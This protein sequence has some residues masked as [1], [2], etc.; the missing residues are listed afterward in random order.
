MLT[1]GKFAGHLFL[2][3]AVLLVARCAWAQ[4][5]ATRLLEIFPAGGNPGQSFEVTIH[6]S[7]LDDA[8]TLH[9]SHAGITA[10][11]K[12]A[13]PG[14]FDDG[15]K[16]VK[17]QFVVTVAGNVPLGVYEARAV[18]KYGMS[19]PRAFRI[20]DVPAALEEEPN[21][22]RDHATGLQLPVS[23]SGR[24]EQQADVDYFKFEATAAGRLVVDCFCRRIDSQTDAVVAVYDA[25]GRILASSRDAQQRDPLVDVQVAAGGEYY[26]KVYDAAYRGGD[27]FFYQLDIGGQPHIDYVFPPAAAAG[28]N[29]PVTVFG[30]NLPGGQPAGVSIDGRPLQKRT[31]NVPVPAAGSLS[32]DR[33]VDPTGAGLDATAY[34]VKNSQGTSNP[35]LIGI[36]TAPPVTENSDNDVAEKAQPLNVPCEVMGQFYPA[37]DDDWYQLQAKAGEQF[38]VEVMSQRMG[39]TTDP[40]LLIQQ[41]VPPAE[42]GQLPE[43]KQLAVV[44]DSGDFGTQRQFDTRSGDPI[45][46]FRAPADGTYRILVRDAENALREDPRHLYRLA[47]RRSQPDFRL[48]AFAENSYSSAHLRQGGQLP[49]RVVAFRQDGFDGEIKVTAQKLPGGVTCSDGVIGPGNGAAALVLKAASNAS[50]DT[51]FVEVVGTSQIDGKPVQRTARL[52]TSIYSV[53]PAQNNQPATAESR[54]ARNMALT[55]LPETAPVAVQAGEG[56]VYETSRAG[57]VKVP[58]TRSGPFKGKINLR[59][60]DLPANVDAINFSINPNANNGEMEVKLKSNTPTGTYSIYLSGIAEKVKYARN[61]EAAEAA[62]NRK[63]EVDK[64]NAEAAAAAKAA[65]D[66]KAAADKAAADTAAAAKAAQDAKQ[67]ADQELAAAEAA[68]KSAAEKAAQ[69]KAAAAKS[70]DDANLKAAAQNAQN[71]ADDAAAK[72]K[73][74]ADAV[75]AAQKALEDADAKAKAADEVKA[76]ADEKAAAAA[77]RAKAATELKQQTDN[78]AKQTAEAAKPKDVNVPVASTPFTLKITPAPFTLAIG[79]PKATVKQGEK[80]EIPLT[81]KRLYDYK[82][83][84]K[85]EADAPDGVGGLSIPDANIAGGQNQTKVVITA[86]ENATPG[87]RTLTVRGTARLNNQN[88]SIDQPLTLTV[89]AVEKPKEE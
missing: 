80:V 49:I 51:G 70:P 84:V 67:K 7:D 58:Y 73:T 72:A 74:A 30:R 26:V 24:C 53:A 65:A 50:P 56:K 71:A 13:E 61:P 32:V 10:K 76:A 6:G 15:P 48:V 46:R 40:S 55:V 34:R 35:I 82:A 69:A 66:E 57:I 63:E 23:V 21:N 38:T 43:I 1:R 68:A 17:N 39:L 5:P 29:R 27:G 33:F 12:M 59:A 18:G 3:A 45:H 37:R 2:A 44:S 89:Q 20:G 79:Q 8:H 85:V 87:E 78:L 52:G 31:V 4:L 77:E 19:N 81:I 47:V 28:G 25:S 62:A 16:P 14:P 83:A 41:V 64:I 36:A 54:L 11:Q 86:A 22:Q 42:E 75:D 88:V 9:F 60:Q